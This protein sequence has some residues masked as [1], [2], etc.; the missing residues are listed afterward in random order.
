MLSVFCSLLFPGDLYHIWQSCSYIFQDSFPCMVLDLA[1]PWEMPVWDLEDGVKR[2]PYFD[3]G[4]C[5]VRC[6]CTYAG[7]WVHW[8]Q[9]PWLLSST[10]PSLS[11]SESGSGSHVDPQQVMCTNGVVGME[12]ARG[13]CE[14]LWELDTHSSSSLRL[15]NVLLA[16]FW[17]CPP[18]IKSLNE[19]LLR[20]LTSGPDIGQQTFTDC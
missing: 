11:F 7:C 2:P 9:G 14:F 17:L 1:W 18:H 4:W 3:G 20:L 19:R 16:P 15:Q 12:I 6:Y 10:G 13:Q 8:Q 5:K